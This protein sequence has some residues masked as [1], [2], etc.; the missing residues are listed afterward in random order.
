MDG[1]GHGKDEAQ[2]VTPPR[3]EAGH[4]GVLPPGIRWDIYERRTLPPP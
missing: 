4:C 1:A 3:F 2:D